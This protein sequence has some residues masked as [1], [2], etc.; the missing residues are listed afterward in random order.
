MDAKDCDFMFFPPEPCSHQRLILSD[1]F[2]LLL[3]KPDQ[4]KCIKHS[5]LTATIVPLLCFSH[6][7]NKKMI[8]T[9]QDFVYKG[10]IFL[11]L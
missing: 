3:I 4:A 1:G 8:F 6:F 11:Y 5:S 9:M 10:F 7:F 2:H